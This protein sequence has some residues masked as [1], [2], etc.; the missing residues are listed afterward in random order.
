VFALS[1]ALG[2]S[3][4]HQDPAY[5]AYFDAVFPSYDTGLC[6]PER[7][8]FATVERASARRPDELLHVGDSIRVDV[9]GAVDSGWHAL[10]LDRGPGQGAPNGSGAM[11][12]EHRITGLDGLLALLPALGS[13][14]A[15]SGGHHT[16]D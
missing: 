9:Q 5:Y 14:P 6:K 10:F 7:A 8:A 3:A 11:P 15:A 1:N 2:S 13:H 12:P 4:P 16:H